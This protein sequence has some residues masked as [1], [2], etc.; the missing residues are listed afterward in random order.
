LNAIPGIDIRA[1]GM[2]IPPRG[3]Q[4]SLSPATRGIHIQRTPRPLIALLREWIMRPC[5]AGL[6]ILE[7]TKRRRRLFGVATLIMLAPKIR[8]AYS[9]RWKPS[10]VAFEIQKIDIPKCLVVS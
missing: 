9:S 8:V 4:N 5:D 2:P 1:D 7:K 10:L 3:L 6:P